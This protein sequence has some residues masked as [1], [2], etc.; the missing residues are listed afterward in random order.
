MTPSNNDKRFIINIML[1]LMRGNYTRNEERY[2]GLCAMRA[3][4]WQN[5][6]TAD[7]WNIAMEFME[8]YEARM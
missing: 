6:W 8:W 4:E 2:A 3:V 5:Y 7:E 1:R